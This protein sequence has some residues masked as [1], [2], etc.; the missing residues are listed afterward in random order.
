MSEHAADGRHDFD[1]VLG[2]WRVRNRRLTERWDPACTTWETF[3]ATGHAA[4]VLGGLG[5]VDRVIAPAL[6]GGGA[7]EGVTLRLFEPATGTLRIW[8]SSSARPGHLDP[9][10]EGRFAGGRGNF[11]GADVVGDVPVRLR[12]VWLVRHDGGGPRW[13]QH[14]S[15]DDG[16]TWAMNWAMDLERAG[17]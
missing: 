7:L 6:P 9:P 3:D 1:F 16:A 13:E 10:M 2:T 12:F 11:D 17:A 5:H 14:W 4:P 15:P 8:W